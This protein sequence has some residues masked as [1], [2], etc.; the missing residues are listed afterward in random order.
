MNPD[1]WNTS[2]IN[3]KVRVF[4]TFD[5]LKYKIEWDPVSDVDGY[6][7]YAGYEPYHIRSLISGPNLITDTFFEFSIPFNDPGKPVY[8][9]VAYSKN[10]NL[11]FID[12][13][14][15]YALI[16]QQENKFEGQ[17]YYQDPMMSYYLLA[18]DL[19][20][21]EEIRRRIKGVMQ[22]VGEDVDVYIRQWR[23]LPDPTTQSELGLDPNYQGMSR[24]D[25]TYGVG[26]YPGYFPPIRMKVR[27]GGM[28]SNAITYQPYGFRP[29][30]DTDFWTLWIPLLSTGDMVVRLTNGYRYEIV[31]SSFSNWRGVPLVQR[32]SS[33]L[34]NLTSPLYKVNE[35]DIWNKWRSLD[36]IS[37]NR[38]GFN[39]MSMEG[40]TD[41][42][43]FK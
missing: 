1:L 18:D 8:F 3:P 33:K 40:L 26:V 9:W 11:Q 19:Y 22:E 39:V 37:Y 32:F 20:R 25:N 24:N 12:E 17:N 6:R 34:I 30:S 28:P 5:K 10:G 35:E 13:I 38:I 29:M 36:G 7:V 43:I 15:S 2:L 14:G 31:S 23:G 41:Y 16:Y 42:L 21:I 4:S 27:F